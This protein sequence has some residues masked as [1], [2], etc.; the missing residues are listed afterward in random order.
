MRN[1]S[2]PT[3]RASSFGVFDCSIFEAGKPVSCLLQ[4]GWLSLSV[5]GLEGGASASGGPFSPSSQFPS[6]Q[7]PKRNP[8]CQGKEQGRPASCFPGVPG[9]GGSKS[10]PS[11]GQCPSLG[12]RAPCH[13]RGHFLPKGQIRGSVRPESGS[14]RKEPS[15]EGRAGK[16]SESPALISH[17]YS[18]AHPFHNL[19]TCLPHLSLSCYPGF[20]FHRR[21]AQGSESCSG[22]GLLSAQA[23]P[24]LLLRLLPRAG[25]SGAGGLTRRECKFGAPPP[26]CCP[27]FLWKLREA[28]KLVETPRASS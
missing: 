19:R 5:P 15:V 10:P 24:A 23:T 22:L 13:K 28:E 6:V 16:K 21:G 18:E 17:S 25:P 3:D 4:N 12:R 2:F 14:Q 1:L 8:G 26:H 20:P 27:L 9:A 7:G 11:A